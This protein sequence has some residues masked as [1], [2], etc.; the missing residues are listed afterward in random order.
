MSDELNFQRESNQSYPLR[1]HDGLYG[2]GAW[3]ERIEHEAIFVGDYQNS[4]EWENW[5][6][7]KSSLGCDKADYDKI[8]LNRMGNLTDPFIGI[9]SKTE[10]SKAKKI[11]AFVPGSFCTIPSK[12]DYLGEI[13][14]SSSFHRTFSLPFGEIKPTQILSNKPK[15]AN[16]YPSMHF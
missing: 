10:F 6:E 16:I 14:R 3:S 11:T 1:L 4:V 5:I 7:S 15:N 9:F 8:K 2:I 13:L 12:R